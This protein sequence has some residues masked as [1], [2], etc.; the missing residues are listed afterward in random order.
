MD[1]QIIK[2]KLYENHE[3]F[4][5]YLDGLTNEE[6]LSSNNNKWTPGQQLEHIYLSVKPVRQVFSLPKF[7]PKLI[8]GQANRRSK[9]YDDLIKKYYTKLENGGRAT[10]RFIPKTVGIE[11]GQKLK[12]DL[13]NEV[14]KLAS[15]IDKL[16]ED[17]LDKYIIPHP[18]LGK[19]TMRE[20]LYFTIYHVIHHE[21][22]TKRNLA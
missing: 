17:E 6:F 12:V 21:E 11:M 14:N 22:V 20:M 8:W 2:N 10:S 3:A 5:S 7:I 19:L 13:K 15:K 1:K 4:I 16:T 9:S 18:L